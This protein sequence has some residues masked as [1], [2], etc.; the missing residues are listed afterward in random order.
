MVLRQIIQAS[1]I[2][3]FCTWIIGSPTMSEISL[4]S[5]NQLFSEKRSFSHTGSIYLQNLNIP[6]LEVTQITHMGP[7]KSIESAI[8]LVG[9]VKRSSENKKISSILYGSEYKS[10][11]V[12]ILTCAAGPEVVL[13]EPE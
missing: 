7:F 5:H 13:G 11:I 2:T 10:I 1:L 8:P 3:S 4:K 12:Q 6:I 9:Q